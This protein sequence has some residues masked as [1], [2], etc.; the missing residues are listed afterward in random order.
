MDMSTLTLI[1]IAWE[2]YQQGLPKV[3]V[4]AQLGKHRETVHLW[5][6]GIQQYG[7]LPF[8]ERY[9]S[10]IS[11]KQRKE[12]ARSARS[13]PSPSAGCGPCESGRP[14]AVVRRSPTS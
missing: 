7:L 1:T 8:L 13:I 10:E 14:T 12:N 6:R 3:R 9:Q 2:L 5:I 4:A 11:D